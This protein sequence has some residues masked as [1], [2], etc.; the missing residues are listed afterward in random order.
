MKH[1]RGSLHFLA[2]S[3]IKKK[4]GTQMEIDSGT[5]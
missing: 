4:F 3:F 5:S 1:N 2:L